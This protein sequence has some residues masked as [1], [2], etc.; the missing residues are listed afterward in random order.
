[1]KS[2]SIVAPFYNEEKVAEI[3]CKELLNVVSKMREDY[4]V[5]IFF[6]D[7]GSSDSTPNI[8]DRYAKQ[9]EFIHHLQLTRN[10]GHQAA[11]MAGIHASMSDAI[12]TIDSD[13]QDPPS[14][15]PAMVRQ[16]ED[17]AKI[18]NAVRSERRGE[19]HFKKFTANVFYAVVDNLAETP[20]PRQVGDFRLID[21]DVANF[22]NSCPDR[23]PYVR[24][25][26]AWSGHVQNDVRYE[27]NE[28]AAGKT[29]YTLSKMFRLASEA[30][31]GM[32]RKPLDI[33]ARLL[34]YFSLLAALGI[35]FQIIQY[36]RRGD[37]MSSGWT[38]LTILIFGSLSLT[39]VSIS[40]LI[41][42]VGKLYDQVLDRPLY[43]LRETASPTD[44]DQSNIC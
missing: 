40:I 11:I 25:L 39:M 41:K 42:Y 12:I 43:L 16:W 27:R 33:F 34:S 30:I 8:L 4:T 26:V 37:E 19:S 13:L 31:L 24:G 38:S 20:L 5:E 22:L 44:S 15:I 14:L 7:D 35:P 32:S 3:F 21:R 29:H 6:V 28:R 18:V 9:Y 36:A 10:F 17:G 2:I 23:F 1:M